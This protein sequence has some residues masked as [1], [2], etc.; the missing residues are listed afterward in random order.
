MI[1]HNGIGRNSLDRVRLN[2]VRL[3]RDLEQ[4]RWSSYHHQPIRRNPAAI[5]LDPFG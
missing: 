1:G 5:L 3:L 2:R 4:K